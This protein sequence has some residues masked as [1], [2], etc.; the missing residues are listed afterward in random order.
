MANA[1]D[2]L[3]KPRHVI[4]HDESTGTGLHTSEIA[5][6]IVS[7]LPG[8]KVTF[9]SSLLES[10]LGELSPEEREDTV[11]RVAQGFARLKIR[12]PSTKEQNFS[13][14]SGEVGYEQRRLSSRGST[15]GLIYRGEG[16]QRLMQELL[17]S[18]ERN[19]SFLHIVFT[20]Q[21]FG[22]WGEDGRYHL[23]VA[24]YGAPNLISTTG[25]VEAL[26]KP[27]EFYLLKQHYAGLGMSDALTGW[28][29]QLGERVLRHGDSRLTEVMKGYVMQALFY[30]V[31]GDPFCSDKSCR[32]HNAHWHEEAIAAQMGGAYEFCPRHEAILAQ[33]DP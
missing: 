20:N 33:L 1:A 18:R 6:Y 12:N 26:S 8:L 9:R 15:Y 28:E 16:A 10:N 24:V 3:V 23:R 2:L 17:P 11:S 25:L 14:L 4:L 5:D 32:L 27:R 13:V 30:H 21:F 31:T 29:K 19:L 22:T 7:L